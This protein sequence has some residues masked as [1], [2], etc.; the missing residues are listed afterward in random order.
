MLVGLSQSLA[1]DPRVLL[2]INYAPR[3]PREAA[4]RALAASVAVVD[5]HKVSSFL[6]RLGLPRTLFEVDW[7]DHPSQVSVAPLLPF[8][9]GAQRTT[10]VGTNP[11]NISHR[12]LGLWIGVQRLRFGIPRAGTL[13]NDLLGRDD[14]RSLGSDASRGSWPSDH[15]LRSA[16]ALPTLHLTINIIND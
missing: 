9:V 10:L 15:H 2:L 7:R 11:E 6:N 8:E 16:G 14:A 12:G 1:S 13:E 4:D 3:L 5:S